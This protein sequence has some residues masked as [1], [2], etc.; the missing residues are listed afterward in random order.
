MIYDIAEIFYSIQGEGLLQGLPMVFIRMAGCNL[1]CGFCDTKY[2]LKKSKKRACGDIIAEIFKYPCKKI[3][4]TGGEPFLQDLSPLVKTLKRK[5]YWV[6]AET[7]GTVWRKLPLDW[8]T[9]SPKTGGKKLHPQGYDRRFLKTAS[10]FKYVITGM[11]SMAFID[12]RIAVPV[13][14][15]PVDNNVTIAQKTAEFLKNNPGGNRYLRMQMHKILD[16]K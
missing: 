14:L 6:S 12:K 2:A 10:E 1:R 13:M 3:C 4:I 15:Q 5:E 7:N 11:R 8:L 16:M 9:V